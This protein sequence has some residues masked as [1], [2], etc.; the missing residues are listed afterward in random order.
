MLFHESS[1]GRR[2]SWNIIP[3]F[4]QKLGKMSQNLSSA[5]VMIGAWRVN[6]VDIFLWWFINWAQKLINSAQKMPSIE[7]RIS[8]EFR[9]PAHQLSANILGSYM[10]RYLY[11]PPFSH[12]IHDGCTG[13][14]LFDNIMH[15]YGRHLLKLSTFY[16]MYLV[17]CLVTDRTLMAYNVHS[18]YHVLYR[19]AWKMLGNT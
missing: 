5:A 8:I 17:S 7:R 4:C 12:L 15:R 1:V 14:E 2:F 6:N 10:W 13:E 3:Y 11:L 19:A 18:P 16:R 9:N